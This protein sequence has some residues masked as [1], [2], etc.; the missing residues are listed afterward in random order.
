MDI[1]SLP[2]VKRLG[3]CPPY[4]LSDLKCGVGD[5]QDKYV[6]LPD[7]CTGPTC[8]E[9]TSPCGC[10]AFIRLKACSC[11]PV[12]I[13]DVLLPNGEH[14]DGAVFIAMG[15]FVSPTQE[16]PTA[17]PT[18]TAT[19]TPTPTP[20]LSN[21]PT[22]T[23]GPTPTLT[24][25][26]TP[27]L[28]A[29]VT[30]TPTPTTTPTLTPTLTTSWWCEADD[31]SGG[32]GGASCYPGDKW[33]C[34]S[35]AKGSFDIAFIIETRKSKLYK[36]RYMVTSREGTRY[37]LYFRVVMEGKK[38]CS[39][40]FCDAC[41]PDT[42]NCPPHCSRWRYIAELRIYKHHELLDDS[43][44]D[45]VKQDLVAT[46]WYAKDEEGWTC[47]YNGEMVLDWD[48]SN[49]TATFEA[50]A[51]ILCDD[52][53][54]V[55]PVICCKCE[56]VCGCYYLWKAEYDC[57]TGKWTG[58]THGSSSEDT[59]CCGTVSDWVY[60]G[61]TG[62]I[63]K[64]EKWTCGTEHCDSTG[65]T[66]TCSSSPTAPPLPGTPFSC[67]CVT[68]LPTPTYVPPPT[69]S[70]EP[71]PGPTPTPGPSLTPGLTP[72]PTP[73][74][75][76]TAT[77]GSKRCLRTWQVTWDCNASPP[78]T[79]P[80]LVEFE[81]TE[82]CEA[83]AYAWEYGGKLGSLCYYNMAECGEFCADVDN[84][85]GGTPPTS[86]PHEGAAPPYIECHCP[87][88]TATPTVGPPTP[89]P[90]PTPTLTPGTT[91]THTPAPEP[92]PTPTPSAEPGTYC[93]YTWNCYWDCDIGDY[94]VPE[95]I[96]GARVCKGNC[97]ASAHNWQFEPPKM[98]SQ[99]FY[100]K[101]V[102]ESWS[103][104]GEDP[105]DCL[106]HAPTALEADDRPHD[107]APP[108]FSECACDKGCMY[109][110]SCN[111]DCTTGLWGTVDEQAGW[112]ACS[113]TCADSS[114][115]LFNQMLTPTVCQYVFWKCG[116]VCSDELDCLPVGRPT[117]PTKPGPGFDLADCVCA[118]T[119]TPTP[120]VPPST[121]TPTPSTPPPTPT[122]TPSTEWW[123]VL[124][125]VGPDPCNNP[126]QILSYCCESVGP[127]PIYSSCGGCVLSVQSGPYGT[128]DD[129][130]VVC[131]Y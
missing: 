21:T 75:T 117:A 79:S 52:I 129:C 24:A 8:L 29:T 100:S 56:Y 12:V 110:W 131:G 67:P 101:V 72:T 120:T 49:Y 111:Y 28:T 86:R 115:W 13:T 30:Y 60:K 15:S 65:G 73:G 9:C 44:C 39:T 2:H 114:E 16:E 124:V 42:E 35:D 122:P 98:G 27:T 61:M 20:T 77:P 19:S 103:C 107:D 130:L 82:N 102:C 62:T 38:L 112:T 37:C 96:V 121:P 5:P 54:A 74:P 46:Y 92:T 40:K 17:T 118:V 127:P 47:S 66:S 31:F 55:P 4:T 18:L 53:C 58:P 22:I 78:Y 69:P 32:C 83:E 106:T 99:C 10:G 95:E 45:C 57:L 14:I 91:P 104:V 3:K 85:S 23:H 90:G 11:A 116:W 71:T 105:L 109:A 87:T 59:V 50:D 93:Q 89:T 70:P 25:T 63:C 119:P 43:F 6:C 33:E 81:C 64:Y 36:K 41:D 26:S 125:G 113:I 88:P 126:M 84:C 68:P 97:A 108:P 51:S 48:N 128:H 1:I 80:Q 7:C 34:C 94:S 76:P 123:C